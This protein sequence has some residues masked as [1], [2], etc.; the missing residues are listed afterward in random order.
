MH[1]EITGVLG[2]KTAVL[3]AGLGRT[4]EVVGPNAAG[5]SSIAVALQAVLTQNPDPL[6]LGVGTGTQV[7]CHDEVGDAQVVLGH[8]GNTIKWY[9]LKRSIEA[10]PAPAISSPYAVGMVNFMIQRGQKLQAELFQDLLLPNPETMMREIENHLKEFLPAEDLKGVLKTIKERDFQNATV[11]YQ[12]R[13]RESKR[14]WGKITGRTYGV[15]V[16][17]DW[18]PDG[19]LA[20]YDNIPVPQAKEKVVKARQQLATLTGIHAVSEHEAAIIREAAE[21]LPELEQELE[22]AETKANNAKLAWELSHNE[23]AEGRIV[24]CGCHKSERPYGPK[25]RNH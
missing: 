2:I 17:A 13:S 25:N 16:A 23:Y 1:V 3:Y 18:R 4:L 21:S 8:R 5:K 15:K 9:P 10:P 20:D 7:Y 14:Q 24:T 19:W 12:E 6:N 11:V 22:S